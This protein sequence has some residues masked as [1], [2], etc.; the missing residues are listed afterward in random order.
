M[1]SCSWPQNHRK[2]QKVLIY[3]VVDLARLYLILICR[4]FEVHKADMKEVRRRK[5]TTIMKLN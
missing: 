4:F 2:I 3:N 5:K 1:V